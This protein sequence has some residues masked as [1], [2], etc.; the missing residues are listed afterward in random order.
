MKIDFK[1]WKTVKTLSRTCTTCNARLHGFSSNLIEDEKIN[2]AI[3]TSVTCSSENKEKENGSNE[4]RTVWLSFHIDDGNWSILFSSPSYKCT[5][6][7]LA[8][9]RKW[10]YYLR[11]ASGPGALTLVKRKL[12]WW[13]LLSWI[14]SNSPIV[15]LSTKVSPSPGSIRSCASEL[16]FFYVGTTWHARRPRKGNSIWTEAYLHISYMMYVLTSHGSSTTN[17]CSTII[18]HAAFWRTRRTALFP[19]YSSHFNRAKFMHYI[20]HKLTII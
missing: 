17:T 7:R 3:F 12:L 20:I 9:I 4:R 18:L 16:G 2:R 19:L 6:K 5:E 13:H 11:Q 10:W 15:R 8:H 14:Y 1:K